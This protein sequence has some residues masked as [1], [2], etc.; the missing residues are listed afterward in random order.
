M[1]LVSMMSWKRQKSDPV[2]PASGADFD[3]TRRAVFCY[4]GATERI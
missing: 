4:I 2:Q 1:M 3:F